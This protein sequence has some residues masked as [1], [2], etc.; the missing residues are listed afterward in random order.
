MSWMRQEPL[1]RSYAVTHPTG[2]VVPPHPPG[3]DLLVYATRGVLAVVA[4]RIEPPGAG[5]VQLPD[6]GGRLPDAGGRRPGAGAVRLTVP[7]HRAAWL[8]ASAARRI[9]VVGRT[10]L[11]NLYVRSGLSLMDSGPPRVLDLPPLAR[12]LLLAA[13]RR[14]PLWASSPGS[15]RLLSVL[16]DELA[17]LPGAPLQLPLPA[18]P[19]ALAVAEALL[20]DLAVPTEA[21]LAGGGASRRTLE[22]RFVAETG[23]SLGR[24]R[25]RARLVESVRLLAAGTTT[26]ATAH[27]VGFA[28]PSAFAAAFKRDLGST[29]SAYG[30]TRRPPSG[31]GARRAGS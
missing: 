19:V 29:P 10:S 27:A 28:T 18:D 1:A 12:E 3:W 26:A 25:T 22:R 16:L 5:G 15:A 17:R 20:A 24:W 30:A 2:T 11:R 14:A 9:E 6:A 4:D 13:V 8:P 21:V 23:M 7:P 31:A